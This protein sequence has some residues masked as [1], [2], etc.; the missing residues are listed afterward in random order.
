LS[1]NSEAGA[2]GA[3]DALA[4]AR[5]AGEHEFIMQA[6]ASVGQATYHWTIGSDQIKWS[7][8]A[9]EVLGVSDA[10]FIKSGRGYASLLDPDNFTS[11]FEAVMHSP[12]IDE[13]EGVAFQ[14]EY[15]FRPRGRSD[16]TGLWLEDSGR[17]IAGPDGRPQEVFGVIRQINDRHQRDQHLRF[18]GNCD[19]LTGMMNRGRMAEALGETM[20][21]SR[22]EGHCCAFL[23]AAIA[24]LGVVNDAYGFDIADEVIITIGRRLRR[25]VRTGDAIGRYSGAKFGIILA[26]CDEH[27]LEMAAE[28]FLGIARE[29]VIDTERGPVWAMLSIGGLVLPK[30]ADTPNLAMARAEEALAEARRLP[31]DGFVPFRPSPERVSARSLNAQCAAEI[32]TGLKEDRFTLAFQPIIDARS[33]EVAMHEALLRMKSSDGDSITAAHLIPIAEKLGL[34]RLIDRRVMGLALETLK[35]FSEARLTLNISGIT[36]TDPRW[37]RQ[38]VQMAAEH[39]DIVRRLTIEITETAAL[40]DLN[41]IIRFISELQQ[42]GCSVAVD[43]FGAGYTSFRNLKVLN[44]DMVK[45]DGSFCENLS[46]NRDNQYFV[47]S[48]I[49]LAKKFDLKTVAEW[50]QTKED[51]ILLTSWGIDYLQGDI[52]GEA[53][54]AP[55][56]K[57][58]TTSI[59]RIMPS[60]DGLATATAAEEVL[61]KPT[62]PLREGEPAALEVPGQPDQQSSEEEATTKDGEES[63]LDFSRLRM[64]ISALDAQFRPAGTADEAEPRGQKGRRAV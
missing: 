39:E 19:P 43:D 58:V 34:V 10:S 44:V 20:D 26:N 5:V 25:V 50:V 8:N 45:L 38:L 17:W 3:V 32:V 29:S 53:V 54:G 64:A 61:Q 51:A 62:E 41:E 47:R 55:P 57:A 14:I 46:T 21:A 1:P 24:N 31:T 37:F 2:H 4:R 63:L 27:E 23:I 36:A 18:L 28:R 48:L 35:D 6:L 16:P 33:G 30:L 56:W 13:G 52:F 49:D 7:L 11:R 40:H 42:F 12:F 9:T 60:T 59:E 15:L 22:R